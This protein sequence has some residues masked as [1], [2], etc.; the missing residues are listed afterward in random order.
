[1]YMYGKE[2][3]IMF[4]N[5]SHVTLIVL[6]T[7][8]HFPC[9]IWIETTKLRDIHYQIKRFP[10]SWVNGKIKVRSG[11]EDLAKPV[12]NLGRYAI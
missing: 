8:G 1:M 2:L 4:Y 12:S 7:V 5:D 10:E 11:R 3:T 6:I 9:R